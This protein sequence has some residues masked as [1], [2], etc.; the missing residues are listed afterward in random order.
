M[1]AVQE[2]SLSSQCVVLYNF[3]VDAAF[4]KTQLISEHYASVRLS[5]LPTELKNLVTLA[6]L[7][8]ANVYSIPRTKNITTVA[9]IES[10][11]GLQ[12][13]RLLR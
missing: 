2:S 6:T 12:F 5:T 8:T 3:P 13:I 1:N 4:H 7:T 10:R 11:A 9:G